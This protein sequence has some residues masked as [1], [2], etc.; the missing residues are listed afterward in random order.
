MGGS[1]RR[2][3]KSAHGK[4]GGVPDKKVLAEKLGIGDYGG[5]KNRRTSWN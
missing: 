2:G 5:G 4:D 3:Y 1:G